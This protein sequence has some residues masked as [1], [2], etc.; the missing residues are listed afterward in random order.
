MKH[1]NEKMITQ[2]LLFSVSHGIRVG[3]GRGGGDG[4]GGRVGGGD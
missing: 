1:T 4:S 3:G 2:F